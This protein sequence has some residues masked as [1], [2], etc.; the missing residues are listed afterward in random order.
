MKKKFANCQK[1]SNLEA[2]FTTK[3]KKEI[4][5]KRPDRSQMA[6]LALVLERE[7]RRRENKSEKCLFFVHFTFD[8]FE[9]VIKKIAITKPYCP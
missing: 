6:T 2:F 5:L 1:E 4:T 9:N 3:V 8:R 7:R